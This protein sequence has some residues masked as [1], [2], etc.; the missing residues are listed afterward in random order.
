MTGC[1]ASCNILYQ[2]NCVAAIRYFL[3]PYRTVHIAWPFIVSTAIWNVTLYFICECRRHFSALLSF[4]LY[5]ISI[6]ANS[7]KHAETIPRRNNTE[8]HM[9]RPTNI[10]WPCVHSSIRT[11][12]LQQ[13]PN[14]AFLKLFCK[15][16]PLSLVRMF[17]GPLSLVRM[18][19]EPLSLVRMFY[20]PLSLVRMFYGPPYSWDYQTH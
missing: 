8:L 4:E 1:A 11:Q 9:S 19:Y 2:T 5:A 7:I 3:Q 10:T 16:G 20:G 6:R 14:S 18:F 17:Y 13:P 12:Q 15:W